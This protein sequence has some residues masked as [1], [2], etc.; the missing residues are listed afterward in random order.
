MMHQWSTQAL[1]CEVQH[2]SNAAPTDKQRGLAG[3][4]GAFP[5]QGLELQFYSVF[6]VR[7][8]HAL[9]GNYRGLLFSF[10]LSTHQ[11]G[12][13]PQSS[14]SGGVHAT[15]AVTHLQEVPLKEE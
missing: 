5:L 11:T 13:D 7:Q 4:E 8:N 12:R 9:R 6:R 14:S 2:P 10:L 3:E 15:P 1:L